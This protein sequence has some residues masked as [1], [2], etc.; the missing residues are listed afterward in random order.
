[1]WKRLGGGPRYSCTSVKEGLVQSSRAAPLKPAAMPL[2]KGVLPPPK[3]P[4]SNTSFGGASNSASVRPKA[5]VSSADCVVI[6]RVINLASEPRR[7]HCTV[8]ST[9][10]QSTNE[11]RRSQNSIARVRAL[12]GRGRDPALHVSQCGESA[13]FQAQQIPV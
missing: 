4:R 7:E 13:R 6:S 5:I 3:S 2:P 8:G 10:R 9:R 1:M 11:E 12:R